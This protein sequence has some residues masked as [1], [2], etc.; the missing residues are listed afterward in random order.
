MGSFVE[1]NDTLQISAAQG[2]PE[3]LDLEAHL[4]RPIEF[5]MVEGQV[6]EFSG[7]TSIR[8]YQ[9]VPVRVFLVQNI[10]EKWVYWGLIHMLEVTHDY[11]AK[12]TSGKYKIVRLNSPEQMKQMFA[13][14]DGRTGMDYFA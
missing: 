6:F 11:V 2:F 12:N 14:T 5:E 7:K 13:L 9:Q 4:R 8:N 3:V 10:G 1:L